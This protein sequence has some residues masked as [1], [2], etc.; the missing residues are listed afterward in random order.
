VSEIT[1]NYQNLIIGFKV[2]VKKCRVCF[3]DTVCYPPN[4][5]VGL[6]TQSRIKT[7]WRSRAAISCAVP[8]QKYQ[9]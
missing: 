7:M 1:K 8:Y 3:W 5:A 4:D 9:K 2:T 6:F